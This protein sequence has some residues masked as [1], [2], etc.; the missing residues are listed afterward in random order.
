MSVGAAHSTQKVRAK[1]T[2]SLAWDGSKRRTASS[3]VSVLGLGGV[4]RSGMG[5]KIRRATL[6]GATRMERVGPTVG[7]TM[8]ARITSGLERVR[9]DKES[10]LVVTLTFSEPAVAALKIVI[11]SKVDVSDTIGEDVL[12]LRVGAASLVMKIFD[13]CVGVGAGGSG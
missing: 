8:A 10:K 7:G 2:I 1:N 5:K 4:P 9:A 11:I 13:P 12:L 3:A 6:G